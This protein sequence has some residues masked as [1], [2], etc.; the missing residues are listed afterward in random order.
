MRTILITNESTAVTDAQVQAAVA[1][2]Q[3]QIDRDFAPEWGLSATLAFQH[4]APPAGVEVIHV[5]DDSDQ[6]GALGYHELD[7]ADLPEGFVFAKTTIDAGE[8][9]ESC[10]S[11]ETLEQT[12]RRRSATSL[13]QRPVGSRPSRP[14]LAYEVCDPVEDD[15]YTINGVP[16]SNFVTM[17][18]FLPSVPAGR[19]VDF[20]GLLTDTADAC[21]RAA[22]RPTRPRSRRGSR[23]SPRTARPPPSWP[24][25]T[26]G[27]ARRIARHKRRMAG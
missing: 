8:H 14:A 21:G 17:S 5:L 7:D 2:I 6:A 23:R 13:A 16:V 27:P 25:R 3:V 20:L 12:R 26:V 24:A 19:K 11:H 9:W 18:W 22:T 15:E 4:G 1:A 10:L